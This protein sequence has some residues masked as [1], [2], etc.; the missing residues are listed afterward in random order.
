MLDK[1][2]THKF[3]WQS[4]IGKVG[5]KKKK[6]L[7]SKLPVGVNVTIPGIANAWQ[8]FQLLDG[9]RKKIIMQSPPA[10]N[11]SSR[12]LFPAP[13]SPPPPQPP[14]SPYLLQNAELALSLIIQYVMAAMK[15]SVHHC[16]LDCRGRQWCARGG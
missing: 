14:L 15:L 13:V 6:Q 9:A 12:P 1:P 7:E 11:P 8:R 16:L 2:P 4:A 3:R 10:P 5:M